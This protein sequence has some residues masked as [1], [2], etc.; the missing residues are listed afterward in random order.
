MTFDDIDT[1][2][3]DMDGTLLDL[4]FDHVVWHRHLPQ[5]YAERHGLSFDA[6]V[7]SVAPRLAAVEGRLEWYCMAHWSREF[8]LDVPALE[9]E[10]AHLIKVRPGVHDFLAACAAAGLRRV[11]ATNAH[12]A[13]LALKMRSSGLHSLLDEL[14]SSHDYGAPK[15]SLDFWERLQ[16]RVGFNP[17]RS[18]LIDDNLAV[19]RTATRFGIAH[20]LAIPQPN[21][22]MAAR[23]TEEFPA[24]ACFSAL[25]GRVA[26]PRDLP[27]PVTG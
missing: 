22:Q 19:L 21:S 2:L 1:V 24:V 10:M 9:A 23:S 18:V 20:C 8:D 17:E 5:R 16:T 7:A 25:V 4:H 15:E 6:A 14:H 26:G 27:A 13:S 12:P 11:L 3:L